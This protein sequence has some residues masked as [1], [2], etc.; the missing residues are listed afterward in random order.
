MGTLQKPGQALL[1]NISFAISSGD[2]EKKMVSFKCEKM[3]LMTCA[4]SK[5]LHLLALPCSLTRVSAGCS[6]NSQ[7]SSVSTAG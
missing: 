2:L 4:C 3:C 6:L 1:M 7:G 5:D